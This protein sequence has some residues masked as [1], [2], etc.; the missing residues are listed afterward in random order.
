MRPA[1]RLLRPGC[2]GVDVRALQR[3]LDLNEDGDFGPDTARAVRAWKRHHDR[4]DPGP[5]VTRAMWR[6]LGFSCHEWWPVTR[7]AGLTPGQIVNRIAMESQGLGFPHMS[8]EYVR[9]RNHAHGPTV[10][11]NRSDHQ[12]PPGTAWAADI[13]NGSSPTREMDQMAQRIADWFGGP[14]SGEGICNWWTGG[15][16]FQ[17]LYRCAPAGAGNHYNHVHIG[18]RRA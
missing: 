1:R 7:V 11:G 12:G 18:V 10:G 17:M 3:K 14:W 2:S 9:E 8:V 16:R 6:R 4:K 15:F 5:V 13:S